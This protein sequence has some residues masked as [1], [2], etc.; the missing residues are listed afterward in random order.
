MDQL[1]NN[2]HC[3]SAVHTMYMYCT[4]LMYNKTLLVQTHWII[5][6]SIYS[7]SKSFVHTSLCRNC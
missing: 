7:T 2:Q 1:Q 3:K 4:E 5:V 6:T